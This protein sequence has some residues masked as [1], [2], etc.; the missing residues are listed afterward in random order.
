[1]AVFEPKTFTSLCNWNDHSATPPSKIPLK[2]TVGSRKENKK[3][4]YQKILLTVM[5]VRNFLSTDLNWFRNLRQKIAEQPTQQ[6]FIFGQKRSLRGSQLQTRLLWCFQIR[7][8]FQST[9]GEK[10]MR[11]G[12]RGER[13]REIERY[14]QREREREHVYEG[15]EQRVKNCKIA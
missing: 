12:E 3:T 4:R 11:G 7:D 15:K 5:I 9:L 1:M 14:G 6:N 10:R 13:E 2:K 8:W